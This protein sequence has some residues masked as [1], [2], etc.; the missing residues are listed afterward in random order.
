MTLDD[1]QAL[2]L[3]ASNAKRYTAVKDLNSPL[4]AS[5]V[6]LKTR[7]FRKRERERETRLIS[8]FPVALRQPDPRGLGR[9]G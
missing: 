7:R 6:R 9:T 2:R 8:F 1:E 4:S 5:L 3:R